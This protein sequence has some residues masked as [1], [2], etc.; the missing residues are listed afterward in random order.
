MQRIRRISSIIGTAGH[1]DHGKSTLIAA[2]TGMET[3]RLAEEKRRGVSIELGFAYIDF[4]YSGEIPGSVERVSSEGEGVVRAAIVDVPG[5]E[6][7]IRT[8]LAGATGIDVALLVVAADDGVMPQTVEHVDILNLLGVASGLVVISKCDLVEEK[9]LDEVEGEVAA[10]LAGTSFEDAPMVRYSSLRGTGLD[11]IKDKLAS[12]VFDCGAGNVGAR[13]RAIEDEFF[14]L[15]ID[16]SFTIKGFGTVVT[17][18]VA[19]GGIV[20]EDVVETFPGGRPVK[21]R[22]IQSL[23]MDVDRVERGERA[24]LNLSGIGYKEL[25]RGEVLTSIELAAFTFFGQKREKLRADVSVVL[26]KNAPGVRSVGKVKNNSTLMLH[27]LTGTSLVRIRFSDIKALLPGEN[28]SARL[29]FTTPLVVLRGDFFVLRD[30]ATNRTVGGG[31]VAI[32][33]MDKGLMPHIS[34]LIEAPPRHG[35]AGSVDDI[36]AVLGALLPEGGLGFEAAGLCVMLNIKEQSL[37]SILE[38][39]SDRLKKGARFSASN[40]YILSLSGVESARAL[41]KEA[42]QN[43]HAANV[44]VDGMDEEVLLQLLLPALSRG[45]GFER[46]RVVIKSIAES[47]ITGE[48]INRG[49]TGLLS[50]PGHNSKVTSADFEVETALLELLRKNG[51]KT[52]T[53]GDLSAL[54]F[55]PERIDSVVRFLQSTGSIVEVRR[56]GFFLAETVNGAEEHLRHFL[57]INPCI[58]V[59]E[60]RDLLGCGRKL[61]IELLEYFDKEKVTLRRGDERILR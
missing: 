9:R 43:F 24:A 42:I 38:G 54:P 30:P 5:H 7:F 16:R 1:V 36:I 44:A 59:K 55:T 11:E 48:E 28:A 23:G 52:T 56:G 61:A 21:A 4:E 3:D 19:S 40:G 32:P 8:M 46:A 53:R 13:A 29:L 34:S 39:S 58:E 45:L 50:L 22:G 14:R 35:T 15:P 25:S 20:K 41:I 17:G 12:C 26:L 33:Y 47:M 57:S 27:H 31:R 51:L 2:L 18:T 49:R 60:F 37:Q 10:L 6:R